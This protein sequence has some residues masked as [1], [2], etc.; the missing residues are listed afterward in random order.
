MTCSLGKQTMQLVQVQV[1][2]VWFFPRKKCLI[3][4]CPCDNLVRMLKN[5]YHVL[6][7][8]FTHDVMAALLVVN[9]KNISILWE[10]DSI[11]MKILWNNVCC[12]DH[13]HVH[14]VTWLQT[15]N[16]STP[17]RVSVAN[18]NMLEAEDNYHTGCRNISHYQQQQR[19]RS[20]YFLFYLLVSSFVSVLSGL[21]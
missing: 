3:S 6:N 15:K 11:F 7:C 9:N 1:S 10:V 12:V 13:Q 16:K 21:N 19:S 2:F 20:T 4:P 14:H 5:G 18:N 8:C 17:L